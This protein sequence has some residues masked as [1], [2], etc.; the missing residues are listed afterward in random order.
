MS[1]FPQSVPFNPFVVT[2]YSVQCIF[3]NCSS[4]PS[5]IAWPSANLAVY[6][7][8]RLVQPFTTVSMFAII[9]TAL[10][11]GVDMGIYDSKGSRLISSGIGTPTA[12]NSIYS[13]SVAISLGPGHYFM[14]M[15][16]GVVTSFQSVT[17]NASGLRAVGSFQ[18]ASAFPL[19]A[20]AAFAARTG[21]G[22][23][24]IPIF[25]ITSQTTI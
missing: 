14:A 12:I 11:G 1:D 19:P 24:Y 21:T 22:S 8:I 23:T 4:S 7:P 16:N 20:T 17:S 3:Q 2:T 10:S 9:G 5:S 13:K 18:Q 25:G 15:S 6:Y